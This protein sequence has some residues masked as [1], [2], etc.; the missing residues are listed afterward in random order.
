MTFA[1]P[2]TK[3]DDFEYSTYC[4]VDGC[5]RLWAVRAD[6]DKP[7]CSKHQWENDA[8]KKKRIFPDLPELKVKTVSQWYDEKEVF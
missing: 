7:K 3:K 8:P 4:S 5:G 1:K 6:G 2:A